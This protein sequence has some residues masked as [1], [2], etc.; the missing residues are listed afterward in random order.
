MAGVSYLSL[1]LTIA[2]MALITY[3][4]R[5]SFLLLHE[6][7]SFPPLVRRALRYVPYAVLAGL[8]VPAIFR[9]TEGEAFAPELPRLIA[10][11]IGAS[12]AW[13]TGSV[14]LTLLSG[15]VSLWLGLW[16]R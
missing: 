4:L 10:A 9:G 5:A 7:L 2:A 16:L 11:L 8:L 3:A 12:V 14:I 15:M 6:R 1:W 13:R